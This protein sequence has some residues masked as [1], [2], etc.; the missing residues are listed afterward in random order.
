MSSEQPPHFHLCDFFCRILV[1]QEQSV[2]SP[3]EHALV[4][5]KAT[6]AADTADKYAASL[7]PGKMFFGKIRNDYD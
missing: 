4:T 6:L 1:S 7:V 5:A 2:K 3:L